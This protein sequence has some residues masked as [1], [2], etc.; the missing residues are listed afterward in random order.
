[1]DYKV[2]PWDEEERQAAFKARDEDVS[3]PKTDYDRLM[4]DSTNCGLLG[5][6]VRLQVI[7]I[8]LASPKNSQK[9]I[10]KRR[11]FF[12]SSWCSTR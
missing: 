7:E 4:Q 1:M 11:L 6:V 2:W 3:L 12:V 10:A 5:Q 8:P 9:R